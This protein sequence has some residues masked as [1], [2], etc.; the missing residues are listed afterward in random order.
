MYSIG[1]LSPNCIIP[2][3][4]NFPEL[5]T[6]LQMHSD[7]K[8]L[9]FKTKINTALKVIMQLDEA[10]LLIQNASYAATEFRYP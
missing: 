10:L 7:M 6:C 1:L 3:R 9:T 2:Q 8:L 4:L 5:K